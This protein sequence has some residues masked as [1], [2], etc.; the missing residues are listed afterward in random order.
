MVAKDADTNPLRRC[1]GTLISPTVYL[2]VRHFTEPHAVSATIWFAE[3]VD[4]GFPLNC[5]PHRG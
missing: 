2:T 3:Y 5:H 4:T 1:S